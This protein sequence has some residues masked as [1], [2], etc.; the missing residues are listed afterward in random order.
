[1]PLI[2]QTKGRIAAPWNPEPNG[3]FSSPF[4]LTINQGF[5]SLETPLG[6]AGIEAYEERKRKALAEPFYT[7]RTM[8]DTKHKK[9][10][11][12]ISYRPPVALKDEFQS[13]VKKSGLSISAFITKSVFNVTPPRQSRHPPLEQKQLAKLL[14]EAAK[15]HGDLQAIAQKG[16]GDDAQLETAVEALTEIRTILMRSIGRER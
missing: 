2:T 13:R 10:E 1:M 11:A 14:F 7:R 4:G 15:I 12:P 9:R 5:N 3:D 6:E 8:P 16:A